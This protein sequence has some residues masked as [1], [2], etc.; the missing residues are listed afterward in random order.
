MRDCR[1]KSGVDSVLSALEDNNI[2]SP[3]GRIVN[4]NKF[5]QVS[6]EFSQK[7]L[8]D[9]GII[10]ELLG[11]NANGDVMINES[12]LYR[13][14]VEPYIIGEVASTITSPDLPNLIEP[15]NFKSNCN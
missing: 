2:V 6:E 13:L 14:T 3:D 15:V 7:I 11:I 9:H 12:L 4:I 10:G 5:N 8:K 1:K